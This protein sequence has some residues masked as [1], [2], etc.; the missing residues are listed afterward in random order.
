MKSFDI[1]GWAYDAALHCDGCT[2]ARFGSRAVDDDRNPPTDSEGNEI[3]PLFAGD[4]HDPAGE[5]CDDCGG[6]IVE[7]MEPEPEEDEDDDDRDPAGGDD[8]EPIP[9]P[10]TD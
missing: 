3:H 9:D 7:P 5:S 10:G 4:E 8:P 1:I 2:R 6:E